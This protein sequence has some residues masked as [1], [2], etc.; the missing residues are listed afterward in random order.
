M[1][2]LKF[3]G[4]PYYLSAS[5][6][7]T[8]LELITNTPS[9]AF[10]HSIRVH[11]YLLEA[12]SFPGRKKAAFSFSLFSEMTLYRRKLALETTDTD[13]SFLNQRKK[14]EKRKKKGNSKL[15]LS[16]CDTLI[17]KWEATS[18]YVIRG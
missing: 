14:K 11:F 2:F 15:S 9:F 1:A 13:T 5:R 6:E 17:V 4:S 10:T 7:A 8:T 3:N 16:E 12:H 18:M